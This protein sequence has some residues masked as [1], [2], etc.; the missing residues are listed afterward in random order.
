[1]ALLNFPRAV[2]SAIPSLYDIQTAPS[3]F[4][5]YTANASSSR[6]DIGRIIR[7]D[8]TSNMTVTLNINGVDGSAN[9]RV[10]DWLVWTQYNTGTVTFVAGVGAS[11][12]SFNNLVAIEGRYAFVG[13]QYQEDNSWLLAG[14]LA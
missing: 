4:S 3:D 5:R 12:K 1:M 9:F 11:L 13:S 14:R 2:S 8:S 10:G 6:A 7:M